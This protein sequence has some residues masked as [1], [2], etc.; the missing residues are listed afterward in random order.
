MNQFLLQNGPT[1][2][3]SKVI[4]GEIHNVLA[5]LKSSKQ[6][7]FLVSSLR[8]L[9]EDLT[10]LELHRSRSK[11]EIID[12]MLYLPPFCTA[13]SSPEIGAAVTGACLGSIHK[14]LLYGFID[15]T[16]VRDAKDGIT[17]IASCIRR[18]SFEET[19]ANQRMKMRYSRERK[20]VALKLTSDPAGRTTN[21]KNVGKMN[22]TSSTIEITDEEVVLKLLSLASLTIRSPAGMHLLES[23]QIV[24]IFDTCLHVATQVEDKASGLLKSA[25]ADCLAAIVL[26]VFGTMPVLQKEFSIQIQHFHQTDESKQSS[27]DSQGSDDLWGESDPSL[28]VYPSNPTKPKLLND[29][30]TSLKSNDNDDQHELDEEPAYVTIMG[31]LADLIDPSSNSDRVVSQALRFINIALETVS[32]E[33]L[34]SYPE[35]LMIM[36]NKLCKHLLYLSTTQ[37]LVILCQVGRTIFNLFNSIKHHLKVQ[38]EVFLTSVHLRILDS[39]NTTIISEEQKEI[40]LESLL[41]F[42]HEPSLM[43]DLYVNYD[44]DVQCSNL[45]ENICRILTA[46]VSSKNEF[47]DD[48]PVTLEDRTPSN[49][50]NAACEGILVI[51]DSIARRCDLQSLGSWDKH[52]LYTSNCSRGSDTCFETDSSEDSES[53]SSSVLDEDSSSPPHSGDIPALIDDV[54]LHT[55]QIF[56]ER[57]QKKIKISKVTSKFNKKP[58]GKDWIAIGEKS[59]LFPNP[60]TPRSVAQFLY[61]TPHLDKSHIGEYISKGPVDKYLFNKQVLDVFV[62]LFDFTDQTFSGALRA[63][64]LKFRLPGEAQCIDRL[65]EAFANQLYLQQ[66]KHWIDRKKISKCNHENEEAI[67]KDIELKEDEPLFKSS[68]G[69]YV[70]AFSTIMLNTDL[71]N[72]MIKDERRMTLDEFIRNNRGINDGSDFPPGF[73]TELYNQIKN[74]EIQVQSDLSDDIAFHQWEGILKTKSKEV[75]APVF[76][77][78]EVSLEESYLAGVHERDMFLAVAEPAL[79][80]IAS[81]FVRTKDKAFMG[82]LVNGIH[83]IATSSI[84][85]DLRDLYNDALIILLEFGKD[86]I[87][88]VMSLALKEL[89]D[90][91]MLIIERHSPSSEFNYPLSLGNI[92][93]KGLVALESAFQLITSAPCKVQVL[94]EALPLLIECLCLLRD[95]DVLPSRFSELDDFANTDGTK[96]ELSPYACRSFC[97]AQRHYALTLGGNDFDTDRSSLSI[98]SLFQRVTNPSKIH[99]SVFD[100][101]ASLNEW[102]EQFRRGSCKFIKNQSVVEELRDIEEINKMDHILLGRKGKDDM[103]QILCALLEETRNREGSDLI[104]EHHAVYCLELASRLLF[105]NMEFAQDV[106]HLFI[107]R[108]EDSLHFAD[109][110]KNPIHPFLAE[111]AVVTILRCSIHMIDRVELKNLLLSS[112]S[113]IQ[114]LPPEFL[115]QINDRL[116]CGTAVLLH[117]SL[118]HLTEMHEWMLVQRLVEHS[119][120]THDGCMFIFDGVISCSSLIIQQNEQNNSLLVA[121]HHSVLLLIRILLKFVSKNDISSLPSIV[122]A[123]TCIEKL[124]LHLNQISQKNVWQPDQELWCSVCKAFYGVCLDEDGNDAEYAITALEG[125]VL[126]NHPDKTSISSWFSLLYSILNVK[127]VS[128]HEIVRVKVFRLVCKVLLIVLPRLVCSDIGNEEPT[129]LLQLLSRNAQINLQSDESSNL[130][131][132]TVESLTN[133]IN[134]LTM[135]A[136]E[137]K[138]NNHILRI[139]IDTITKE[140]QRVNQ[141]DGLI[142]LESS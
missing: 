65:M 42:C 38:L 95:A 19:E 14:F 82:K 33:I 110:E 47:S 29:D 77:N 22:I 86:Y 12:C 56:V 134:V 85:F 49:L 52:S 20:N 51:I 139:F 97:R 90:E 132:V 24:G 122:E 74:N 45:F 102:K 69:I 75:A 39:N 136:T 91:K 141:I 83:Q 109:D 71:H 30:I 36:K 48:D 96:L 8:Q 25:A 9:N 131:E 111:R 93:Q 27:N 64:L 113:L 28:D 80:S 84:Y 67:E 125:L 11:P 106:Y 72:P 107:N 73:M 18:C 119:M 98:S 126:S 53:I 117:S 43:S 105:N 104:F 101:N 99:K 138:D 63:F 87:I 7:S 116:A 1:T 34:S 108:F 94:R 41:E 137:R 44:C 46:I 3:F 13:V 135:M 6:T 61:T 21:S 68:D 78:Y 133:T 70:L 81:M 76:T 127:N 57:K 32:T 128:P 114:D 62:S 16:T 142:L 121:S 103:K 31:R 37:D 10:L 50:Q 5:T 40:A 35:L 129:E 130:Y 123:V 26:V 55:S 60:A 54:R 58:F 92:E 66:S 140:L 4:K 118:P 115:C 2:S 124:Y 59:G 17:S 88:D 15:P 120:A 89:S 23:A 79:H 100:E 112:L